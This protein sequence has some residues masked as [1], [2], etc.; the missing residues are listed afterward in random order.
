MV[1]QETQKYAKRSET[2]KGAGLLQMNINKDSVRAYQPIGKSVN[3]LRT[4]WGLI[5][6]RSKQC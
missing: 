6:D 1:N 5:D 3:K 2:L 4:K